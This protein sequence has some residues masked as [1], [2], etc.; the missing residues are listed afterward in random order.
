MPLP[1]DFLEDFRAI[2]AIESNACDFGH[3]GYY[4]IPFFLL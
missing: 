3:S 1:K 2:F 4:N